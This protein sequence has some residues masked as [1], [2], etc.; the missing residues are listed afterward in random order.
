MNEP[1]TP[2]HA[3]GELLHSRTVLPFLFTAMP[4]RWCGVSRDTTLLVQSGSRDGAIDK[5]A[6]SI[7]AKK[8]TAGWEFATGSGG[9]KAVK[10]H[11]YVTR[12]L[13]FSASV[14]HEA[15][16]GAAAKS[17]LEKLLLM[18]EPL[19]ETPAWRSG[20][21]LAAQAE[22]APMVQ[23]RLE[24][25]NSMGKLASVTGKVDEVKGIMNENIQVL[26]ENHD[27]VE[28]LENKSEELMAQSNV[29]RKGTRALKRFYLWQNAKLGAAAGTATTAG[30]AIIA[31]PTIGAAAGTG[32][33]L[34]VGLGL[35]ATAGIGVGVAT[36]VTKNKKSEE[37]NQR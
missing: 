10:L 24:Q 15:G 5:L 25:A 21:H 18:T 36:T 28:V 2:T 12:E 35:A 26:L 13:V 6:K 1:P 37:D 8:P 27:R 20:G 32:V 22:C 11:I 4:L 3:L 23:Q 29:F 7:L 9:L 17:F 33:G 14:I 30:V 31:V 19:Q 16:E 34:G